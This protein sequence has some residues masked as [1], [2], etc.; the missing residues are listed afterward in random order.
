MDVRKKRE[1]KEGERGDEGISRPWP[2]HARNTPTG[3]GTG[4][5]NR[6]CI[7]ICS[8][9]IR[10]I[11]Y[12]TFPR[13]YLHELC[14]ASPSRSASR[15]CCGKRILSS[16]APAACG[17][18]R[19]VAAAAASVFRPSFQVLGKNKMGRSGGSRAEEEEEDENMTKMG[20]NKMDRL[21]TSSSSSSSSRAAVAATVR[22]SHN[23]SP[24]M[25]GVGWCF[26]KRR[27][28]TFFRDSFSH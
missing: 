1:A 11:R 9:Q 2:P 28:A 20:G 26:D 22:L 17:R 10:L 24:Q 6:I 19:A 5:P 25:S 18:A 23:F 4:W 8:T 12:Q 13:P 3:T 27:N 7:I 21:R 16:P 15:Q 14:S